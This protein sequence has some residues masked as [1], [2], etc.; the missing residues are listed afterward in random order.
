MSETTPQPSQQRIQQLIKMRCGG[1]SKRLAPAM[2]TFC[3]WLLASAV[4]Q[5]ISSAEASAQH[6]ADPSPGLG[7]RILKAISATHQAVG[8]NTNLGIVLLCA[9]LAQACCAAIFS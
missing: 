3:R 7:Q 4:E 2:R 1:S 5:F 8:C 6:I 9:P